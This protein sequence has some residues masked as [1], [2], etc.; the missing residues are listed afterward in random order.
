MELKIRSS[1]HPDVVY[2]TIIGRPLKGGELPCN[3][4]AAFYRRRCWHIK[5][6]RRLMEAGV[7]SAE[8]E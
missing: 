8:A 6:A 4:P 7:L 5:E 3:C 1:R 2:T